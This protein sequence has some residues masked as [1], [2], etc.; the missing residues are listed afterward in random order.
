[1]TNSINYTFDLLYFQ[2]LPPGMIPGQLPGQFHPIP[3]GGMPVTGPPM[4]P[5]QFIPITGYQ[6]QQIPVTMTYPAPYMFPDS[7]P[8]ALQDPRGLR[9]RHDVY[10]PSR[11][12][13]PVARWWADH[14]TPLLGDGAFSSCYQ[15]M[16][17]MLD[18]F[19]LLLGDME[20]IN[21][22]TMLLSDG[23]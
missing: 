11:P 22:F 1:M 10:Q 3:P 7:S 6:D 20:P 14:F 2:G 9:M 13:H 18:H 8:M 23:A 17:R 4:P 21:H 15:V 5:G 16:W 12:F 19:T